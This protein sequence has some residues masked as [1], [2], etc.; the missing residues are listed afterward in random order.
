MNQLNYSPIGGFKLEADDL[1]FYHN[2]IKEGFA[3]VYGLLGHSFL[4]GAVLIAG[5]APG[6]D[7]AL[8]W[9]EGFF[10]HDGEFYHISA[11]GPINLSSAGDDE[12]YIEIIEEFDV[13][14]AELNKAGSPIN[15][16]VVRRAAIAVAPIGT[17]SVQPGFA[18]LYNATHTNNF[19]TVV[20]QT[21]YEN[22]AGNVLRYK[23]D[24]HKSV[25]MTGQFKLTAGSP[26]GGNL[27]ATGNRL[28]VHVRPSATVNRLVMNL[29]TASLA[30]LEIGTNGTVS[31]FTI[32][33]AVAWATN[34]I[35]DVGEIEWTV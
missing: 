1:L 24:G 2:A 9:E 26:S 12:V 8:S 5:S 14:G 34:N 10:W 31:L 16:Y 7:I 6:F 29:S 33:G 21:N 11:G 30:H 4:T 22:V 20:V 35:I 18:A 32:T 17:A 13:A 3:G 28:P 19:R 27:T 15:T 25:K 23:S